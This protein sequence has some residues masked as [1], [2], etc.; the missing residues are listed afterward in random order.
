MKTS[1]LNIRTALFICDIVCIIASIIFIHQIEMQ[2]N[3]DS[4]SEMLDVIENL[5]EE[6]T[7]L[8]E[9]MAEGAVLLEKESQVVYDMQYYLLKSSEI[10]EKILE[11]ESGYEEL[12][13][14]YQIRMY[15][16]SI[17][18][19]VDA[20]NG[21]SSYI[22]RYFRI[23]KGELE[24]IV[25]DYTIEEEF[26]SFPI[27]IEESETLLPIGEKIWLRYGAGDA[28]E[29]PLGLFVQNPTVDIGYQNIRAGMTLYDIKR[30]LSVDERIF[31]FDG[32]SNYY[33]Y[34]E[35]ASYGYYYISVDGR[36]NPTILYIEPKQ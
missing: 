1:Y 19:Q 11:A 27:A 31:N 35:D 21:S 18:A 20:T 10:K 23:E 32:T 12:E 15:I 36:E 2:K 6:N 4:E 7:A 16:D 13:T 14:C 25:N 17:A 22:D 29:L 33:V 28:D 24:A 34:Y 8:R 3:A 5:T 26:E 9:K 30:E